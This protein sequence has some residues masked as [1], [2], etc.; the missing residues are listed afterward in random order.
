MKSIQKIKLQNFKRFKSLAIEFA[1]DINILIGDNESGKSSILSAINLVLSGSKGKI[2]NVGL[3]S[4]FNSDV[5]SDYL[6][7]DKAYENLPV[8]F[9]EVFL[10]E[11]N[12]PDLNGNCN[13]DKRICDGLRLEC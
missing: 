2:E 12:N 5:I 8:L 1:P 4:L 3:E 6:K 9:I 11:Q 13:S 7:T 10:N